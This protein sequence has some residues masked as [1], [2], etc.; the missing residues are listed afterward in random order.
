M[1]A[2]TLVQTHNALGRIYLTIIMPFHR[3]VAKTMLR[4][5]A[6]SA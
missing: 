3:L 5:V 1:T 6:A 4:Q 2:T